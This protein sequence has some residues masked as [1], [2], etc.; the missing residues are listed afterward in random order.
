MSSPLSLSDD[1]LSAILTAAEPLAPADRCAFVEAV[2]VELNGAA[3][4]TPGTLQ[5]AIARTQ[6]RFLDRV[7]GGKPRSNGLGGLHAGMSARA[8]IRAMLNM[9]GEP[10]RQAPQDGNHAKG[11]RNRSERL[12]IIPSP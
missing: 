10:R 3:F 8:R 5:A 7:I 11:K 9:L 12:V 2:A 6:P 1:Q 4:V